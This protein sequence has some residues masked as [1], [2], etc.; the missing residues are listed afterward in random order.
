MSTG[1]SSGMRKYRVTVINR[2]E[3]QAGRFGLDSAGITWEYG[4]TVWA[5]VDW[6]KGMRTLN[7]GAVDA[8]GVI[9]VRMNWNCAINMRSRIRWNGQL[10]QILPETFHDEPQANTIQFNA[11]VIINEQI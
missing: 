8:Y 10:Y 7:A 2:K 3:A 4:P 5:A 11:Q 1:Y 6:V 9:M